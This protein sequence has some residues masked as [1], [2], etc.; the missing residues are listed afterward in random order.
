MSGMRASTGRPGGNAGGG[1]GVSARRGVGIALIG[2]WVRPGMATIAVDVSSETIASATSS[3]ESGGSVERN[4]GVAGDAILVCELC[5][6]R[7][8]SVVL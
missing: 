4:G 7:C 1:A 2:N 5:R 6:P 8:S 3:S